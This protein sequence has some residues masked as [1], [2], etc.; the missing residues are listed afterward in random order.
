ML[1]RVFEMFIAGGPAAGAVA[2]RAGHRPVAGQ[3]AGRDARRHGRGP[4]RRAS[5]GAA[6]SSCA[7]PV[8][9]RRPAPGQAGSPPARRPPGASAAPHPGRGR[10]P[11]R[12]PTAWR[13]CCELM[14]HEVRTAHDGLEAVE[15]AAAVPAR[16]GPARHRH[17]EA[18]RLRG[19]PRRI[20]GAAVGPGRG[21]GGP[22][23]LG[24]G[25]GQ[26]AGAEAGF[27]HHLIKPVDP[28]AWRSCCAS[29][30]PD[31]T[32]KVR[33][34]HDPASEARRA[35]EGRCV[36]IGWIERRYASS[37]PEGDSCGTRRWACL[38]PSRCRSPAT[39]TPPGGRAGG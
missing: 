27:D 8:A 3:A 23:R 15:A 39:A 29:G 21:A 19:V 17:A 6:S 4:Q 10:Q 24:P 36:R 18:E 9:R 31:G 2:G 38:I 25:G 35:G 13:C 5:A 11:G 33:L 20:R 32:L 30:L 22:D 26:A 12:A 1:P 7:C 37:T 34:D 16:R 28:A 14:G